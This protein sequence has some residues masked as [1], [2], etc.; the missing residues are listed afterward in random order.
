[1]SG[2]ATYRDLA[3]L[4]ARLAEIPFLGQLVFWFRVA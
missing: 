3:R 2:N 1:M 4:G